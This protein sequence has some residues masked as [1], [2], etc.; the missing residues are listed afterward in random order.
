VNEGKQIFFLLLLARLLP[1][2]KK[3]F[4][5]CENP[6]FTQ[7]TIFVLRPKKNPLQK[8]SFREN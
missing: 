8:K 1:S 6:T 3:K 5:F 4:S 7:K 2:T